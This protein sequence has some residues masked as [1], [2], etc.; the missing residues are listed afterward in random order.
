MNE[1]P[2]TAAVSAIR[3]N[4]SHKER[5]WCAVL[6]RGGVTPRAPACCRRVDGGSIAQID[7][8]SHPSGS[9]G[10]ES[11]SLPPSCTPP[12]FTL[13]NHIIHL[14]THLSVLRAAGIVRLI[15]LPEACAVGYHPARRSPYFA[16]S[17]ARWM[18]RLKRPRLAIL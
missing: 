9:A 4:V 14:F 2:I 15:E 8:R 17:D 13:Q 11:A 6:S 18:H 3:T 5:T 10:R 12:L 16:L 1:P 7:L